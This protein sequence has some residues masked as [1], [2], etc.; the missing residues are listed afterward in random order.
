MTTRQ[1]PVSNA[2]LLSPT[3]PNTTRYATSGGWLSCAP[4]VCVKFYLRL[5]PT[6]P[7]TPELS[8]LGQSPVETF[9]FPDY[10]S[11]P[12]QSEASLRTPQVSQTP[13]GGR[14]RSPRPR[15][16]TRRPNREDTHPPGPPRYRTAQARRLSVGLVQAR[17]GNPGVRASPKTGHRDVPVRTPRLDGDAL[18][19]PTRLP[20]GKCRRVGQASAA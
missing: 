15:V 5:L 19:T 2:V 10:Q 9:V 13:T 8:T 20:R 16:P 1:T 18:P 4:R 7:G 3:P 12:Q 14:A 17:Q 11:N 6:N